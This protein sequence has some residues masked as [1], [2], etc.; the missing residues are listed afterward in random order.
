M[1][2]LHITGLKYHLY[3]T[4]IDIVVVVPPSLTFQSPLHLVIYKLLLSDFEVEIRLVGMPLK[5][6]ETATCG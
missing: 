3:I 1:N 4:I 5:V 6:F 2:I